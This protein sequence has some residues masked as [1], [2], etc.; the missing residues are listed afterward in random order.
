[1]NMYIYIYI[2]YSFAVYIRMC[3]LAFSDSMWFNVYLTLLLRTFHPA[4]SEWEN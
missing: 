3:V 4:P 2:L 1:M